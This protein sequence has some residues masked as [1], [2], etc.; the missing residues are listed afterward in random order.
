MKLDD[1]KVLITKLNDK[2]AYVMMKFIYMSW[3]RIGAGFQ[4]VDKYCR[5]DILFKDHTLIVQKLG[6][7]CIGKLLSDP[8]KF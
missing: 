6:Q 7:S 4:K 8:L 3:K 2:E 1:V 5:S